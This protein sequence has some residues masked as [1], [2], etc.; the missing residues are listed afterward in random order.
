MLCYN[1]PQIDFYL[2]IL[3]MLLLT[4]VVWLCCNVIQLLGSKFWNEW[5]GKQMT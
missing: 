3:R 5:T 1:L 4:T 2:I